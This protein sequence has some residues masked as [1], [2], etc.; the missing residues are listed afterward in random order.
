MATSSWV[1]RKKTSLI[2]KKLTIT[3]MNIF[4][5][6][7]HTLHEQFSLRPQEHPL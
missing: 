5:S 2:L 4:W 3:K 6:K 7:M 1:Q